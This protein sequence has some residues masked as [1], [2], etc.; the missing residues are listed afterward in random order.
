MS[1][2]F[3]CGQD[4]A[5][6]KQNCLSCFINATNHD[7]QINFFQARNKK[8]ILSAKSHVDICEEKHNT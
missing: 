3:P 4:T 1:R 2:A 7:K 8:A 5:K 6:M